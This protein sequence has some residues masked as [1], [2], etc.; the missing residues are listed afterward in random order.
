MNQLSKFQKFDAI[1]INRDEIKNAPYNP[2]KIGDKEQKAL[3][4]SL[5]TFGLVETLVWNKRTGNLVGGHQR[6]SQI[7]VL[8]KS[9]KYQLTVA[10]VDIDEKTEKELNIALNNASMQGEYDLEALKDMFNDIDINN[11]GFTDYDLSIIGVETDID[12]IEETKEVVDTEENIK[13][14]KEAKAASKE[15]SASTQENYIVV[16]FNSF[17][18]KEIFMEKIGHEPDDRYVKGEV[19]ERKLNL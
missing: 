15:K 8:E 5:K 4:K 10:Q 18:S 14:I 2:R 1:T 9:D 17:A 16:T 13:K 12:M 11:T 19:L 7:D 3:R 6:L